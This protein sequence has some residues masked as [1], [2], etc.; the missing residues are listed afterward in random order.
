RPAWS[1]I[2]RSAPHAEPRPTRLSDGSS[3][4][5]G[6]AGF[7]GGNLHFWAVVD[8]IVVIGVTTDNLYAERPD[9]RSTRKLP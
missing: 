7:G 4:G 1:N 5:R 3:A 9:I 6:G 8:G 2:T